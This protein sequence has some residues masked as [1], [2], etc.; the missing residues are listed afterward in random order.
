LLNSL[1]AAAFI[2]LV[3][4]PQQLFQASFQLSFAVVLSLALLGP[5]LEQLR[6][7]LF[8]Y[9][10]WIPDDLRPRWQHWL[11]RPIDYLTTNLAVALAAWLGSLPLVAAYFNL[12]TPVSLLAN[13]VVVPLSSGALACSLG[14]LLVGPLVPIGGE[15]FNHS[16]WFFMLMMIRA[17]EWAAALPLGCLHV[18]APGPLAIVTYYA[19]LVGVLAGAFQRFTLLFASLPNFPF[20]RLIMR[21][22]FVGKVRSIQSGSQRIANDGCVRSEQVTDHFEER[23][24]MVPDILPKGDE[25]LQGRG[26]LKVLDIDGSNFLLAQLPNLYVILRIRFQ[27]TGSGPL[28][29]QCILRRLLAAV[30]MDIA[31]HADLSIGAVHDQRVIARSTGR[32]LEI[33]SLSSATGLD[34]AICVRRQC[35]VT[36]KSNRCG[37]QSCQRRKG[38]HINAL[39]RKL[40]NP[41]RLVR[42]RLPEQVRI[43]ASASA[44]QIIACC[45]I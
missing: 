32:V 30:V 6:L 19:A 13:L 11:R 29:I 35:H 17:S 27:R 36:R 28:E 4:D 22:I 16:A 26:V 10:P 9:D 42:E 18:P 14:S 23:D 20:T 38:E 12:L 1:A 33:H 3:W 7:R 25:V 31:E 2:I 44:Q 45:P 39:P 8:Q 21:R 34:E 43:G 40:D 41:I 5:V 37:I 15:L 24:D